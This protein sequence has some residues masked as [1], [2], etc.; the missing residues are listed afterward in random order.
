MSKQKIFLA[1]GIFFLIL[2]LFDGIFRLMANTGMSTGIL[3]GIYGLHPIL[4]VF[5]FLGCIVMAERVAGISVIPELKKSPAPVVMVPLIAL[6]VVFEL[7]GYSLGPQ[8]LRYAGGIS[9]FAGSSV[10]IFVLFSLGKKTGARLP[11]NF[12]ILS[13]VSLAAS[14]VFSAFYL[15]SGRAGFIMLLLSFPLVFILGERV[16]LTRFTASPTATRRFKVAFLSSLIAV[17]SFILAAT[18]T[19]SFEFQ[20]A[21]SF[22]GS[23]FLAL[24]LLL[25][26]LAEN[27]NF[28]LLSRSKEPLQKYVISHTKV[29]YSWGIVG[30]TLALI[31]F[32]TSMKI[33]LYDPFIHSIAVGF[34]GTMLLAHGPVILP[35]VTGQRPSVEKLSLL[36]LM[37]LTAGNLIR[38]VG[39]LI[40]LAYESKIL[41][42]I[43]G[44][45][46]WLILIAV[47]FFLR[48]ILLSSSSKVGV[49]SAV[50]S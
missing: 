17:L 38:I 34:I 49:K 7:V 30:M 40:S 24:T 13:G 39:D 43:V 19:S 21:F 36:P 1:F 25:V 6:G 20:V 32:G 12:M 5:G 9:L 28:R 35:S 41:E 22:L 23:L 29:A 31:Y 10:F 18:F 47:I 15:P 42:S 45:S 46:G 44:L 16:E 8:I 2:A 50:Q 27:Q 11:F 37:V 4:M 3:Q 48:Q 33:D 14:A 26:L